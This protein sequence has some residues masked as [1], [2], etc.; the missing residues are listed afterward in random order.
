MCE[1]LDTLR[2]DSKTTY[3]SERVKE[4]FAGHRSHFMGEKM[5]YYNNAYKAMNQ[6]EQFMSINTDGMDQFKTHCPVNV[7]IPADGMTQHLQGVIEHG[8][9]YLM[10]RTFPNVKK[11][12]NLAIHC[13]LLQIE[14]RIKRN[15]AHNRPPPKTL[16]IQFDG[17]SENFN[18]STFAMMELLVA[19]RV[20]DTIVVS[21]L[22]VGHTH[23]DGDAKFGV[24]S[25]YFHHKKIHTPQVISFS[26]INI[27]TTLH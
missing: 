14:R 12:A 19:K 25:R 13:L 21:R 4:L 18:R 26:S 23:E 10:Y 27:I 15:Q 2:N 8:Q 16:F 24:L 22:L 7:G 9:E 3:E 1:I 20:F 11:D 6:P 5:A 17:G